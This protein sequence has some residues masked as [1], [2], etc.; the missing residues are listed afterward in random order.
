MG[1]KVY[2]ESQLGKGTKINI[3]LGIKA[4]DRKFLMSQNLD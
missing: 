4:I 1:G 2:A 3:E